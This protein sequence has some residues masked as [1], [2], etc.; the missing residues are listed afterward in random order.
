MFCQ[1][2]TL[3]IYGWNCS[4][5]AKAHTQCL[6]QAVHGIGGIHTGTGATGRTDLV[7]KFR[8][9]LFG[10]GACGIGANSLE[11]GGKASLL[12]LYMSCKHRSSGH[13]H[14]G[15][16]QSRCS[17]HKTWYVLITIRHHHQCIKLVGNCHTLRG[18]RDQIPGHQGIFH[19]DMSHGDSIADCNRR[20][21]NRHTAG[22]GYAKL[23]SLHDLVQ[24]HMARNDLIV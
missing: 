10:V 1:L 9:I 6:R 3:R 16:V 17:H 21:Y 22:L 14:G 12:P 7:L 20:E 5:S 4:V 24:I 18:I 15:K 11:H 19:A 13:K 23:H 8:H 2:D